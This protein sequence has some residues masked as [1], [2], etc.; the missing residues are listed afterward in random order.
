MSH[1]ERRYTI[2]GRDL[3]YP[4]EFRKGSSALGLFVVPVAGA[5]E[6]I[7]DS[8]FE[9]AQ[10]APG[11]ALLSLACVH[12]TDSDCGEY[13]EIS[14]AFFVARHGRKSL[15]PYV[16]VWRDILLGGA[17]T[18]VWKLPVT[19]A[20]ARDAG[21]FMWG[22]PKTIEDIDFSVSGEQARFALRMEGREV[23]T[24]SVSARGSR[25]QGPTDS[26]VY[27]MFE[28]APHASRLTQEYTSV[29]FGLGAGRLTLGEHPMA[30]QLRRLGLPRRPLIA[31]WM[32]GLRFEMSAPEELRS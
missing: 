3:G 17:P 29:G 27:S 6:L 11:R 8:G 24:Y 16:G 32:G 20:L 25:R 22:F 10:I 18:H 31:T 7:G 23:L 13:D 28:G 9:V 4:T 26:V 14:L 30:E 15:L 5:R 19:S 2:E 12:Y 1:A 21:L